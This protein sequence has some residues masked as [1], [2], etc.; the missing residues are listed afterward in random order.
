MANSIKVLIVDDSALMRVM[1]RDILAEDPLIET[2]KAT[3]G[4]DAL[5]KIASWSP[6]VVTLDV[7]MPKMGGLE[8]LRRIMKQRPA[9][10]IMLSGLDDPKIVF[11]ALK[12][13]ALDFIVKP[14]GQVSHDIGKLS[15]EILVKVKMAANV[16]LKHV[17]KLSSRGIALTLN[18]KFRPTNKK[19]IAIGASSGGPPAL[20]LIVAALP[21]NFAFPVFIVQHLPVGFSKSLAGRLDSAS[22]LKVKEG[23]NGEVVKKGVVYLAPAGSHMTVDKPMSNIAEIIRLD[24]EA[25]IGGLRP[26][27]DRMMKSV[28]EIYGPGSIGVLLTGMGCDGAEGLGVIK[29]NK[30][31]TIVQD[32]QSS[33]VFG[34]PGA[35]VKRGHADKVV[36][37][38]KIAEAIIKA[39]NGGWE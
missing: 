23:E 18:R 36:P 35:A 13:G 28:A 20:E 34:M 33:V 1:I 2:E 11:D 16:D 15:E 22:K 5:K 25:P 27:V 39:V 17:A 8:T 37:L 31:T 14:S 26:S 30:G 10:V 4:E 7:A 21:D 6:D 9:R 32:K 38:K 24:H 12:E 19:A 3:D 29:E